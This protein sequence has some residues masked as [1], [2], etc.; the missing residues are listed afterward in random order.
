MK[1]AL[2][3]LLQVLYSD[4]CANIYC[5]SEEDFLFKHLLVI[6]LYSGV[7]DLILGNVW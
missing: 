7:T 1:R 5:L 4:L 2:L 6:V 3:S